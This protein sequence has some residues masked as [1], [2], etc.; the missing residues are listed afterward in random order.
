MNI[1]NFIKELEKEIKE[2]QQEE[3][4]AEQLLR[5]QEV[6]KT[7]EGEDK[8]ISSMD[9]VERMKERPAVS[10]YKTGFAGLDDILGGFLLKQL[11]VVSAATKSGKRSEERR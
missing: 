5:L 10:F 8:L 2:T 6:A 11:I 9:I 3:Y 7:Y 4:K 1:G